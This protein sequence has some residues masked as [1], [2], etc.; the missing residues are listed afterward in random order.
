MTFSQ[1][2]AGSMTIWSVLAFLLIGPTN[3]E[4]YGIILLIGLLV[5]REL[6]TTYAS[7]EV[8]QR[9][10]IMIYVGVLLF[11][12]VVARRVLSILGLL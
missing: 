12:V 1:K 3:I 11:I 5:C 6:S 9:M 8:G 10:D 4:L 2:L 7:T